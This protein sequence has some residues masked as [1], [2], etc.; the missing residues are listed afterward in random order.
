MY[1]YKSVTEEMISEQHREAFNMYMHR[2]CIH[3]CACIKNS[4]YICKF[5]KQ[6][7]DAAR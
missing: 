3:L 5:F 6:H 1:L 7:H 4:M 2:S